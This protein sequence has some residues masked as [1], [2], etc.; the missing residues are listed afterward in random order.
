MSGKTRLL[1][2]NNIRRIVYDYWWHKRLQR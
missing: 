1:K 2:F